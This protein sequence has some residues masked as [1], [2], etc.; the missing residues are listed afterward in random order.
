MK[1]ILD[2]LS[3]PAE[4]SPLRKIRSESEIVNSI[5]D[6]RLRAVVSALTSALGLTQADERPEWA[7]KAMLEFWRCCFGDLN[8]TKE[9]YDFGF[10]IGMVKRYGTKEADDAGLASREILKYLMAEVLED[11]SP[12]AEDFWKGY[13]DGFAEA[14][15][16]SPAHTAKIYFA[17]G[18]AWR[19]CVELKLDNVRKWYEF[20]IS[21]GVMK[22]DA[23]GNPTKADPSEFKS[24]RKLLK[25]IGVPLTDKGG[26][27]RR[28]NPP[29]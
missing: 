18:F 5:H 9:N 2:N 27:P 8:P 23:Q 1:H 3:P 16:F 13:A 19:L 10:L 15:S 7:K 22:S 20:L 11:R 26:H 25:R 4:H 14:E 21:M 28:N 12:Q 29:R 6:P 24:L 17:I